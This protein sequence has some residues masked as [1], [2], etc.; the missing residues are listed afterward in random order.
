M[1]EPPQLPSKGNM[2]KP[3]E[4][5]KPTAPTYIHA[6]VL[7]TPKN[8]YAARA[9]KAAAEMSGEKAPLTERMTGAN[10]TKVYQQQRDAENAARQSK[11]EAD[12]SGY[13]A[14]AR[15]LQGRIGFWRQKLGSDPDADRHTNGMIDELTHELNNIPLRYRGS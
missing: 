15:D 6:G 3:A 14:R 10:Y 9:A 7:S 12:A 1:K 13:R 8:D 2:G 5:N 4:S 11:V